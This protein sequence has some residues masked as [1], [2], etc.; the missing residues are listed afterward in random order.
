MLC[1]ALLCSA[2][3][4]FALLCFA[5]VGFPP[6]HLASPSKSFHCSNVYVATED[7]DRLTSEAKLWDECREF[8]AKETTPKEG[9]AKFDPQQPSSNLFFRKEETP[10]P[11]FSDVFT[12]F[13]AM[14]MGTRIKDLCSR[15]CTAEVY[16]PKASCPDRL[17]ISIVKID[18]ISQACKSHV[19]LAG[20]LEISPTS[21]SSD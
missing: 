10:L 3:L 12:I 9:Q 18:T 8:V 19:S 13:C 1:F 14:N 15:Y 5:I 20:M 11:S 2:L 4:S 6:L 17:A 16:R 21:M 7:L